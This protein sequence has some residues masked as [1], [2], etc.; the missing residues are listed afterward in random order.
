MPVIVN[1]KLPVGVLYLVVTVIVVL[2][3]PVTDGGLKLALAR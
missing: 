3:L 2:L 1:G